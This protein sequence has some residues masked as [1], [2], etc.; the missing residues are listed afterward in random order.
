MR[1]LHWLVMFTYVTFAC[2][3][4]SWGFGLPIHEFVS[5]LSLAVLAA[6]ASDA[7]TKD[8]KPRKAVEEKEGK[9]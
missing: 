2:Y 1:L 8:G 7:L 4:F 3:V 9:P 5:W 6:V